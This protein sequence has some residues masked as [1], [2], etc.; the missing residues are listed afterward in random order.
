[1]YR[2]PLSSHLLAPSIP[3]MLR[4]YESSNSDE[5]DRSPEG[6][7][8]KF[9]HI[10]TRRIRAPFIVDETLRAFDRRSDRMPGGQFKAGIEPHVTISMFPVTSSRGRLRSSRKEGVRP[11]WRTTTRLNSRSH[12]AANSVLPLRR[13]N[14]SSEIPCRHS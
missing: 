4:L 6:A 14:P 7:R 5:G 2:I 1:V 10:R 3:I 13:E 12:T 11:V 9:C 8:G